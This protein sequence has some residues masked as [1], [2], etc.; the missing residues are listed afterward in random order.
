MHVHCLFLESKPAHPVKAKELLLQPRVPAPQRPPSSQPMTAICWTAAVPWGRSP[1]PSQ[2]SHALPRSPAPSRVPA[3][4]L[5]PVLLS[6]LAPPRGPGPSEL[7]GPHVQRLR[8]LPPHTFSASQAS[9]SAND[10]NSHLLRTAWCR[11]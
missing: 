5:P 8:P 11:L 2:L 10:S 4:P 9:G 7:D 6:P 3:P 1:E